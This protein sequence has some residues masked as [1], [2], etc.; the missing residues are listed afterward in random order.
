[1]IMEDSP[2][3][4]QRSQNTVRGREGRGG[5]ARQSRKH[6]SRAIPSLSCRADESFQPPPTVVLPDD[7]V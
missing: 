1:M 7:S 6:R 5:I 3:V 4:L 2:C